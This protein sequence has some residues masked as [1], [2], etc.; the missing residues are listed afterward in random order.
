M[1]CL[2]HLLIYDICKFANNY[3]HK[4]YAIGIITVQVRGIVRIIFLQVF[5]QPFIIVSIV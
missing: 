1:A 3:K 2:R 5:L 4:I